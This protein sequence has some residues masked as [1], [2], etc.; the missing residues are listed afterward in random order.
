MK[1]LLPSEEMRLLVK[2]SKLYYEENI[3]QDEIVSKLNLSRSKVSRLLQQARSEGVVRITVMA[4]VGIYP[5]L[6]I[7]LENKFRIDEAIVIEARQPDSQPMVSRELGVAAAYYLQRTMEERDVI[8]I[9]W[10]VTLSEMV[11]ALQPRRMPEAQIVQILGGL[12]QPESEV[13]ATDL[14]QRMARRLGC[15]L[16]LLAAP[17]IVDNQHTRSV[18]LTDSH[19]QSA[20]NL[21][22]QINVAFVGVGAPDALPLG[23]QNGSTLTTAE[24]DNL[25]DHGAV[26][27]IALR[28]FDTYGQLIDSEIEQR[29]VGIDLQQLR[30]IP[31]VVGVAG[32]PHKK[33]ALLGALRGQLLNVLI[34]DHVTAS[35]LLESS[36][37]K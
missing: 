25:V 2:V 3:R 12:G 13:H 32:G 8:G 28:F 10:G 19:V 21:F 14:A 36:S 4:P 6:E 18:F 30:S 31:K 17:G 20:F 26:G 9:T 33:A 7:R 37:W 22:P 5:D 23:V 24:L 15:R 29:I 35:A 34:T 27:D 11:D 1:R 16:T